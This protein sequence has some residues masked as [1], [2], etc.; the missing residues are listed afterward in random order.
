MLPVIFLCVALYSA[1]SAT[2]GVRLVRRA[3]RTRGMP[4]LLMGFAYAA[5]P[6]FGYP[7]VVVGSAVSDR[8]LSAF[9]FALGQTGIVLGVASFLFF[10]ARVFRPG[11]W[12]AP[13]AATLGALV[14]ALCSVHR[15]RTHIAVGAAALSLATVRR[16]TI[17]TLVVLGLAYAW[18]ALEGLRHHRL[19]RRRAQ[20]GLGD[21]VVANRF[22][23]WA[24]AG[25][26]Q[27]ASDAVIAYSLLQGGNISADPLPLFATSSVGVVNSTLLVLIFMPPARYTRWLLRETRPGA[28]ATV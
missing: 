17:L 8:S 26:L 5:A 18:T 16:D 14:L 25:T 4:E 12:I 22:L 6:G 13:V 24:V 23:V 11:S 1:M 21:P 2:V 19:M 7:L 9:L 27:C 20:I 15:V 3:A 10:N 28:L